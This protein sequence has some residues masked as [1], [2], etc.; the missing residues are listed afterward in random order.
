MAAKKKRSVPGYNASS[1]ADISFL[2]LIFFIVS[3]TISTDTAVNTILPPWNPNPADS[4]N[5]PK[6]ERRNLFDI[7]INAADKILVRSEPKDFTEIKPLLIDFITNNGRIPTYSENPQVVVVSLK[8][9]NGTSYN[10]YLN[11]YNEIKAAYNFLWDEAAKSAHGLPYASLNKDQQE[12]IFN[13]YPLVLSES[14]P[15]DLGAGQ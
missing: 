2:M 15:V 7:D 11:V 1:L 3:A 4:T 6:I 8:N 9:D 12:K 5:Y 13:A 14:E 10:A